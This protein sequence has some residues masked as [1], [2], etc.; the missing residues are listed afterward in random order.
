MSE[1]PD[2][3]ER[4]LK[5]LDARAAAK[6]EA[7]DAARVAARVLA[8]LRAE[9]EVPAR[10]LPWR[11]AAPAARRW[12][13]IAAALLIVVGA[14]T[15]TTSILSHRGPGAVA[16]PVVSQ[17]LDS[18]DV[19]GLE[20]VLKATAEVRPLAGQSAV[21]TTGSWDDLSEDQ[22]RAVLQAVQQPQAR[23]L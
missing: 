18:L 8:R 9:P 16:L 5:E 23:T 1:L 4:A 21:R 10:V 3:L 22:L 6:A 7:V 13:G 17:G 15:V 14:G 20:S 19:S 2:G 11:G 12:V